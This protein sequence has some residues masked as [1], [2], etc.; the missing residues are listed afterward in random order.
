MQTIKELLEGARLGKPTAFEVTDILDGETKTG[1]R[2]E[3]TLKEDPKPEPRREESPA[4]AHKLNDIAGL[5][6]YLDKYATKDTVVMASQGENTIY[7]VLDETVKTGREVVMVLPIV[8]PLWAPWRN[9]NG[10]QMDIDAF[11]MVLRSNRRTVV[12]PD[13]RDLILALSQIEAKTEITLHKGKGKNCLNGLLVKT[14]IQGTKHE[15]VVELPESLTLRVP[16][17]VGRP[18]VEVEVDVTIT[19]AAEQSTIAKQST[20]HVLLTTD[21]ARLEIEEFERMLD[22]CANALASK[23]IV[24]ALGSANYQPWRYL[25]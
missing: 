9:A 13:A 20:I 23:K 19:A 12:K 7:A 24:F 22:D 18:A 6:A 3:I 5:V 8:H 17:F 25:A 4:R 21:V 14:A 16:L 1:K 11:L 15:E 10:R 2:L